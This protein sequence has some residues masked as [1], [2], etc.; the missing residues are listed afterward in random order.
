MAIE[1]RIRKLEEGH[2]GTCICEGM[3][4]TPGMNPREAARIY[5][6]ICNCPA[7]RQVYTEDIE[8]TQKEASKAYREI[9]NLDPA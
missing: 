3:E 5:K 1:P 4:I 2:G 6:Q 9:L 7:H 8:I